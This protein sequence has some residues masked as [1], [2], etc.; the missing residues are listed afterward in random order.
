VSGDLAIFNR[1]RT[2]VI[3]LR[4]LRRITAFVTDK[5][6]ITDY[7]LTV[8]IVSAPEMEGANRKHLGHSGSTDVIT[9]DYSEPFCPLAGEIIVCVDEA[10]EQAARFR[11]FWQSELARYIVHGIL[12]LRGYDDQRPAAR[13]EMKGRENALMRELTQE[14]DLRKLGSKPKLKR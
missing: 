13:K 4:L 11:T 14:F 10:V 2:R 9:L 8:H 5:V 1:Q 3:D 12:H 7:E 6:Q